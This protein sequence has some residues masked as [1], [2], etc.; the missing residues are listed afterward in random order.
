LDHTQMIDYKNWNGGVN[1]RENYYKHILG[2][3]INS[4]LKGKSNEKK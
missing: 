4:I 2:I 1:Y 3:N